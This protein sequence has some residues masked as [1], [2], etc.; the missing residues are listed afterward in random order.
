MEEEKLYV[1]YRIADDGT[2]IPVAYAYGES[3][4][5]QALY[6]DDIKYKTPEEAKAGWE[7][8]KEKNRGKTV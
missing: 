6:M 5:E 2:K 4:V 7:R 3:W 8:W 1:K